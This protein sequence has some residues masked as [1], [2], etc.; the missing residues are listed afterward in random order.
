MI[1]KSIPPNWPAGFYRLDIPE[2]SFEITG[3]ALPFRAFPKI[4]RLNR[5]IVITEKI[6]GTN[7]LIAI[8]DCGN[9]KAGSKSRWLGTKKGED[10]HGF[11]RWVEDNRD[12]LLKLGPGY[13]YGEWWGRGIQRGYGLSEKRFSLFNVGLWNDKNKP[14]CCHVV[15]ILFS[16]AIYFESDIINYSIVS[17]RTDG[18]I[19][20][21]GF[22]KPEGIVIYHTA[23]KQ[24]FKVTIERDEEWKGKK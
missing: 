21:P 18:S 9:M 15:P 2:I 5:E 1:E 22:M 12:E 16:R 7:A 10:N 20:A 19:A 23:A 17:L 14:S 6:D 13:H 24:Y 4:P 3:D 11:C 8:D